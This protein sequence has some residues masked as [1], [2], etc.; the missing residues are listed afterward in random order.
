MYA[1]YGSFLFPFLLRSILLTKT[2][3]KGCTTNQEK[4]S[5]TPS[6]QHKWGTPSHP[7]KWGLPRKDDELALLLYG[8]LVSSKH[9]NGGPGEL[10]VWPPS[11]MQLVH[12]GQTLLIKA[13]RT[14]SLLTTKFQNLSP[15]KSMGGPLYGGYMV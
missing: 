6:H 8:R 9:I 14:R 4:L 5:T 3:Y 1:L 12:G 13:R 2:N 10:N 7:H 11:Q 15:W